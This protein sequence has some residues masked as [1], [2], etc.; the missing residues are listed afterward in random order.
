MLV[1]Y[2]SINQYIHLTDDYVFI[3]I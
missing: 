3:D 1:G 2:Q